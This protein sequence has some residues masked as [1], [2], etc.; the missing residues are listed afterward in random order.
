MDLTSFFFLFRLTFYICCVGFT[1]PLL[2]DERKYP[3]H[4]MLQSFVENGGQDAFFETF[5]WA[6]TQG[7]ID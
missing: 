3:Y 2:F 4:L 6:L 1:S 7:K 5:R